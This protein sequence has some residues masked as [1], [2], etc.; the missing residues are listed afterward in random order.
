[1]EA[2][3]QEDLASPTELEENLRNGVLLAKLGHFFAPDVVPLRKIY[4]LDQAQ[5]KA[6]VSRWGLV[7]W[8][9]AGWLWGARLAPFP[10]LESENKEGEL[11]SPCS[12][13]ADPI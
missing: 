12:V 3:L 1:M 10:A 13:E 9:G 4:D 6:S 7:R 2:C 11:L 5:F 8:D